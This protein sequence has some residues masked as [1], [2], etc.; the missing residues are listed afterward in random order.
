MIKNRAQ[1]IVLGNG[2]DLACELKSSYGDFFKWM[3][4]KKLKKFFGIT[5]LIQ[6]TK[7][8]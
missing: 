7:I 4:V 1:L 3:K 8:I 2:F 5:D 6:N